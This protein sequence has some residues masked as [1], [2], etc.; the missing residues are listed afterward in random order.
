MKQFVLYIDILGYG[1]L[2]EEE[3]RK[4]SLRSEEVRTLWEKR[5]EDVLDKAKRNKEITKYNKM[6][7]DSWAMFSDSFTN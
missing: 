2:L 1:R 5:V 7:A 3:A 4:L 6:S